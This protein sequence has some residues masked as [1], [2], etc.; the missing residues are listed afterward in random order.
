[1]INNQDK[2]SLLMLVLN[3]RN[4]FEFIDKHSMGTSTSFT[5]VEGHVNCSIEELGQKIRSAINQFTED[6]F[7]MQNKLIE[8]KRVFTYKFNDEIIPISQI[9]NNKRMYLVNDWRSMCDLNL[10]SKPN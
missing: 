6:Q 3:A 1:M 2:D 4:R 9:V 7:L 5:F 10:D 8:E